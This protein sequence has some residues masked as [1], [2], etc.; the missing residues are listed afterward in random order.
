MNR[1]KKNGND[2]S[3]KKFNENLSDQNKSNGQYNDSDSTTEKKYNKDTTTKTSY[4]TLVAII[5]AFFAFGF[6]IYWRQDDTFFGD[7]GEDE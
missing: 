3:K 4:I 2:V 5:L 6:F 7:F 1:Q